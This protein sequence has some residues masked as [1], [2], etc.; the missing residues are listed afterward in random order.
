MAEEPRVSPQAFDVLFKLY[1]ELLSSALPVRF[2][3]DLPPVVRPFPT[4]LARLELREERLDNVFELRD[5]SLLH[6]EYQGKYTA[7]VLPRFLS[8]DVALYLAT[9]LTIHT[10]IFY[11]PKVRRAP[12]ELNI[13]AV[14][15]KVHNV[16]LGQ[17]DGDE[18]LAAIRRTLDEGRPLSP[19]QQV[20]LVFAPIMGQKQRSQAR[21]C[22]DAFDQAQRITGEQDKRKAMGAILALSYHVLERPAFDK[23]MEALAMSKGTDILE[24]V[25][26]AAQAKA[27]E[28]QAEAREEGL[29][30]GLERG[31]AEGEQTAIVRVLQL[32]FP[33]VPDQL[34]AR[35]TQ[36]TDAQR[37]AALLEGAVTTQSLADFERM[38][39]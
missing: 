24:R 17:D 11:G 14:Q 22:R 21:M 35:L 7:G 9:K 1:G 4:E 10:V 38:L 26:R 5:E 34:A 39:D 28:E 16:F 6:H 27:L 8:Y 36:V 2:G 15:Y 20:D 29:E 32:R 3:I 37:L 12:T 30:Q 18:M 31:R 23:L 19:S 25:Y 13:G 33:E